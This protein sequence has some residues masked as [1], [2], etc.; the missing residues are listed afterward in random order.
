LV[1]DVLLFDSCH[2]KGHEGANEQD[3]GPRELDV[4]CGHAEE[5]A[6]E[7]AEF[8]TATAWPEAAAIAATRG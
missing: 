5:L 8:E 1:F 6:S 2:S 4:V 3:R 7:V